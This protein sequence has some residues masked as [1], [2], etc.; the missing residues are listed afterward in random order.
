MTFNRVELVWYGLLVFQVF[1][2]KGMRSFF[3]NRAISSD[4]MVDFVKKCLW[5]WLNVKSNSLDYGT[6]QSYLN[7]RVCLDCVEL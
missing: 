1:G 2:R 3:N 5:N 6:T 4:N 7:P